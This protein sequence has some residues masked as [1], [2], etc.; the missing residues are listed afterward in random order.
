MDNLTLCVILQYIYILYILCACNN[1][2]NILFHSQLKHC[3]C[4]HVSWWKHQRHSHLGISC[5]PWKPLE[6][7]RAQLTRI[8][9]KKVF[10]QISGTL[11]AKKPFLSCTKLT[12]TKMKPKIDLGFYKQW[13]SNLRLFEY[14]CGWTSSE[15]FM[16]LT[17]AWY[18]L[19]KSSFA[20]AHLFTLI[21]LN[22]NIVSS[23]L[24]LTMLQEMC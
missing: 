9:C 8:Y 5:F 18:D 11:L 15:L 4:H 20:H 10:S 14:F 2:G 13:Q 12:L 6:R 17:H 1:K 16:P 7:N 3:H 22:P 21:L 23:W 19:D 24:K